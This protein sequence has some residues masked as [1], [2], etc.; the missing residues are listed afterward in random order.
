LHSLPFE[1]QIVRISEMSAEDAEIIL[2]AH[3]V[4]GALATEYAARYPAKVA[5]VVL[6]NSIGLAMF[7]HRLRMLE[8]LLRSSYMSVFL[9][10]FVTTLTLRPFAKILLRVI[11]DLGGLPV[12]DRL[13]TNSA[14]VLDG[15]ARFKELMWQI[16]KKIFEP[17]KPLMMPV[18]VILCDKD[19]L[20]M[21]P[22][23]SELQRFFH[24][25]RLH[26][27]ASGHWPMRTDA[28][29][30]NQLLDKVLKLG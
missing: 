7:A 12:D 18:E 8:Q 29:A 9:N 2:V 17:G 15:L 21:T 30:F 5:Q 4:G 26:T 24:D 14:E 13:R 25:A 22:S 23:S 20:H 27:L 3:D 28:E 11:Y 16:P 10:P 19:K 1:K 6:V